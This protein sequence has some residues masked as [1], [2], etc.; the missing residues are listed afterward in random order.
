MLRRSNPNWFLAIEIIIG[1]GQLHIGYYKIISGVNINV[2]TYTCCKEKE[3]MLKG[4]GI[5][6]H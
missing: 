1:D 5:C 2:S 4:N 6:E 3:Q